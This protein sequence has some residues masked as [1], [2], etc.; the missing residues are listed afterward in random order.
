MEVV[1]RVLI[2]DDHEIFRVGLIKTIER[3]MSF[4]IIAQ[5]ADGLEA[6]TLIRDLRPDKI[7]FRGCHE[8]LFLYASLLRLILSHTC[9]TSSGHRSP[10][11]TGPR[12]AIALGEQSGT[13]TLC[14]ETRWTLHAYQLAAAARLRMGS[15]SPC[16][17]GRTVQVPATIIHSG[18][19]SI[20]WS[21][22]SGK[23]PP[24][25]TLITT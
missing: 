22:F 7:F 2:A 12:T 16:S 20:P 11:C 3:D 14:P 10:P 19:D 6:L 23:Q 4:S 17:P 5:A 24:G 21:G 8:N 13:S 25:R 1:T 15:R 9:A 18:C